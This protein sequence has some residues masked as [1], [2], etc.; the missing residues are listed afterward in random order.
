MDTFRYW[1]EDSRIL[2]HS[3][4]SNSLSALSN[5]TDYRGKNEFPKSMFFILKKGISKILPKRK[6][7]N[8]HSISLSWQEATV[9]K[10]TSNKEERVKRKEQLLQYFFPLNSIPYFHSRF[11]YFCFPPFS[12]IENYLGTSWCAPVNISTFIF[13]DIFLFSF[14]VLLRRNFTILINATSSF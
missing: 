2:M 12:R 14:F 10:F 1:Q 9:W 4:V 5:K 3:I 7:R 11:P 6:M 8:I 13:V